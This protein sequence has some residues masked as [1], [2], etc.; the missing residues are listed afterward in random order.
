ML[1]NILSTILVIGFLSCGQK[2]H[3]T[4]AT[5]TPQAERVKKLMADTSGLKKAYF[6][7]GCFWCVEAVF[8]SVIGVGEVVSGY[9][10]G[11][12][13]DATYEKVSAGVT[14]HAETVLVYYNPG[15]VKYETLLM[16]FFD[17]QDPTTV[18]GQGP[19]RGKQYRSAI[20]YTSEE[21]K[22]M[23]EAAIKK[24]NESGIYSRPVATTLERYTG[25]YPAEDYHQDYERFNP[26]QGY[27]RAV[28]IPRLKRFQNKHPELLKDKDKK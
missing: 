20:F 2:P 10:G 23:A 5:P 7:S 25:F 17:S 6:A 26:E 1:L 15:L 13:E 11:K 14:D 8:E 9:A 16:V 3:I 18:N 21:E 19:D 28:S 12:A 27:I 24:I 4:P 22:K